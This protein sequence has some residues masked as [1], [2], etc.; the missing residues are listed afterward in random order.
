MGSNNRKMS[1]R[2]H[3]FNPI[4]DGFSTVASTNLEIIPKNV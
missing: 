4:Q 2:E 1:P 3:K